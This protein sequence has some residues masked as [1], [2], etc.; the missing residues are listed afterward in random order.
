MHIKWNKNNIVSHNLFLIINQYLVI[1][2]KLL[3]KSPN[4]KT[5][6]QEPMSQAS[7]SPFSNMYIVPR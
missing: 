5:G 3:T 4:V 1:P 7:L 6:N 2:Y